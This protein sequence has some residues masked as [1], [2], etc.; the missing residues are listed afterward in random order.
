[1]FR[2]LQVLR[3]HG[4]RAWIRVILSHLIEECRP[5]HRGR[6]GLEVLRGA[7]G[8]CFGHSLPG[9]EDIKCDAEAPLEK[10]TS[11]PVGQ[12]LQPI[13]NVLSQLL[14]GQDPEV[15][16]RDL[17]FLPRSHINLNQY[18]SPHHQIRDPIGA[19]R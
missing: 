9:M 4:S 1:M 5:V 18:H 17:T 14:I 8:V 3:S 10:A 15:S 19:G 7:L 12:L 16:T 11:K 6:G 2:C 13:I